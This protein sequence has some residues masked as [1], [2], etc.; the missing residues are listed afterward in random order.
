GGGALSDLSAEELAAYVS[1]VEAVRD[2]LRA[3][4]ITA[5]PGQCTNAVAVCTGI[6]ADAYEQL[7][8]DQTCVLAIGGVA[9]VEL[10][11]GQTCHAG[12]PGAATG[13]GETEQACTEP[14]TSGDGA[15]PTDGDADG[16]D[17]TAGSDGA[18][19]TSGGIG[20]PRPPQPL[21][22]LIRSPL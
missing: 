20:P 22:P 17:T 15:G 18:G 19:E 2:D 9:P 7:V 11:P 13:F 4:C 8:V 14:A 12:L 6:A 5:A 21:A 10:G 16:A 1:T 3:E